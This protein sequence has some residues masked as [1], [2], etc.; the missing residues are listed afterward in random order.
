MAV[1]DDFRA[2]SARV[3]EWIAA[4][5]ERLPELPVTPPVVPGEVAGL[6]PES[7]PDAPDGLDAMLADLDR[8][9]VPGLTH[10]NHPGFLAYFSSS[11]TDPGILAEFIAAALNVNAMSWRTSPAGTELEERMVDWLRQFVGLPESFQ[12]VLH[13][14]ASSSSFTALVA[15]RERAIPGVR[16]RGLAGRGDLGACTL[17]LSDQAHFSLDKAAVAA[18]LGLDNVRRISSDTRYRLDSVELERTIAADRAAGKTPVM[19][20]ATIGTTST[21]SAD[22]VAEVADVSARHDVWLHVDAAYAG[23]AASLPEKEE[24]FRGWERADSI[25]INPHK[26][27]MTPIDCSVLVYRDPVAMRDSLATSAAYLRSEEAANL[28]DVGVALGRRFRALKLWFIFRAYGTEGLRAI[29]RAHIELAGAFAEWLRQNPR[30][31]V[32]APVPFST[33]CFRGVPPDGVP[34]DNF[35]RRLLGAVNGRGPVFLSDTELAS[36]CTLRL[37]VGS[38]HVTEGVVREAYR[39]LDEEHERLS[40][41]DLEWE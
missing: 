40:N 35:N 28:M 20:C 25:V 29:L 24:H 14:T 39:L 9:V 17:Y 11:T 33:V 30:F 15:A 2:A 21:T 19:V 22:P 27:M 23:P 13:D 16:S 7:P 1:T 10:W 34:A 31:E 37:A 5:R 26:W 12:G 6:L 36:R 32:V 3:A 18:G 8:I 38:A 4:Y 41:A